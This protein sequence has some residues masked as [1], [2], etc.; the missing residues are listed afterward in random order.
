MKKLLAMLLALVMAFSLSACGEDAPASNETAQG[1]DENKAIK[2]GV[3]FYSKDDSLGQLVYSYLNYAAEHVDGLEIQWALG[4]MDANSQVA[5]AE[6][7]IAAGCDGIMALTVDDLAIQQIANVCNE[8]GVYFQVMFRS[9][10]SEDI[11]AVL[12][13]YDYYL[14]YAIEDT[15]ATSYHSIEILADAGISK[16]AVGT[17]THSS[18]STLRNSGMESACE[19]LDIQRIAQFDLGSDV[20]SIQSDLQNIL[21]SYD[22]IEA[23]WLMSGSQGIA[24]ICVN[25]LRAH[26]EATGKT[27]GLMTFDPFDGMAQAFEDGILYGDISG[28][29]PLC[30]AAF[31]SLYNAIDGHPLSQEKV[32]IQFP[33]LIVTSSEDLAFEEYYNNPEVQLYDAEVIQSMLYRYNPEVNLDELQEFWSSFSMD[34][35]KEAVVE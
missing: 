14:G 33:F 1:G 29:A 17:N 6:N 31:A 11:T 35:I 10:N 21:D 26:K 22:D 15:V 32:A 24:E 12:D 13:S 9:P 20:S 27:V 8:S 30:L 34:W 5:D 16:I 4:S 2:I 18:T 7:L 19:D 25:T 23:V 28:Q 3:I